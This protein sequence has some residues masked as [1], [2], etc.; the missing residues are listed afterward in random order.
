MVPRKMKPTGKK[1]KKSPQPKSAT[2]RQKPSK[3]ASRNGPQEGGSIHVRHAYIGTAT[4]S[5]K[6]Q[7]GSQIYFFPVA[8]GQL[9]DLWLQRYL[10]L[11]Q[12]WTPGGVEVKLTSGLSSLVNGMLGMAWIADVTE[13]PTVE[14]LSYLM[15]QKHLA[16]GNIRDGL[17]LRIPSSTEFKW[18]DT[19]PGQPNSHHGFLVVFVASPL[20][21]LTNS[22]AVT[23]HLDGHFNFEMARVP[24]VACGGNVNVQGRL[25]YATVSGG[26]FAV[27]EEKV[28]PS[29]LAINKVYRIDP[30]VMVMVNPGDDVPAEYGLRTTAFSKAEVFLFKSFDD[31]DAF[32][33]SPNADTLKTV[34]LQNGD[35]G[36]FANYSFTSANA[37]VMK[38]WENIPDPVPHPTVFVGGGS[39]VESLAKLLE[40]ILKTAGASRTVVGTFGGLTPAGPVEGTFEGE[41]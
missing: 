19:Q 40:E 28:G 29:V 41:S 13:I 4:V 23:L 31:A 38:V 34:G 26:K 10:G 1:G 20:G 18:L 22:A 15:S 32:L 36:D 33:K 2:P 25:N 3:K 24:T 39:A 5:E 9:N 8:P 6:E 12:R 30:P 11:Y 14:P 16:V 21:G 27:F 37:A 7:P 35:I 17:R